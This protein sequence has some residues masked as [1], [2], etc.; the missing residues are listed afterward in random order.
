MSLR[1]GAWQVCGLVG[2][3][4]AYF[5]CF[6]LMDTDIWWHLA[7][8]RFILEQGSPPHFDPFA[9]DTRGAP[10]IDVHWLFQ[11]VA[12]LI[13]LVAGV[14]GLVIAKVIATAAGAAIL[15]RGVCIRVAPCLWPVSGFI[16]LL[17]LYPARHLILERPTIVTLL[18]L[19]I[20]I[21]LVQRIRRLQTLRSGWPLLPLQIVWANC[22][23]L[24]LLG[25][26]VLACFALGDLLQGHLGGSSAPR[27]VTKPLWGWLV[28]TTVAGLATPYGLD[29]LRLP[30]TLLNRIDGLQGDVFSSQISENIPP[31]MVERTT[32]GSVWAFKWLEA[33]TFVSFLPLL[34]GGLPLGRLFLSLAFFGLALTA[35][36]NLLLF[37]WVAGPTVA[38]NLGTA[39][40]AV[41]STKAA[42]RGL[43]V[44]AVAGGVLLCGLRG[45]EARAEPPITQIAPFRIPETAVAVLE[46]TGLA[47]GPIFCSDRYGGF[48]EYRLYPRSRPMM[49]GRFILRSA[50][51]FAEHLALADRPEGFE[52]YRAR[53]G[54]RTVLLPTDYPDRY[55]PLILTLIHDS[56]WRLVYTDGTETLFI[57]DENGRDKLVGIDLK[58]PT[59]IRRIVVDIRKRH[60]TTP[61]IVERALQHLGRLLAEVGSFALAQEILSVVPGSSAEALRAR[62]FYLSADLVSARRV[63][64]QLLARNPDEIESLCLLA[65]MASDAGNQTEALRLLEHALDIDPHH[66][67]ALRVVAKIKKGLEK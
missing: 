11:I 26:V 63:T 25:P 3:V 20:T 65:V 4:V 37:V 9:A 8:G 10:W 30:F 5:S 43:S 18:A 44:A 22:Q 66:A 32:P 64:L 56:R 57:F 12:Y 47:G 19:S 51:Q 48:L 59:T 23:G 46:T 33:L 7:A 17:F 45:V 2:V 29:G 21:V 41:V 14:K 58:D 27:P 28:L 62:V 53:H 38:L 34:R 54:I 1:G 55:L 61:A 40:G 67:L 49:D 50:E 6:P 42:H 13:H 52:S 60:G 39:I 16:V 35:N 15:M 36:R 31:W 24:F